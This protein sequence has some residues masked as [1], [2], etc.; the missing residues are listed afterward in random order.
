MAI[1]SADPSPRIPELG[2]V[3]FKPYRVE[4]GEQ[5][6]IYTRE[7]CTKMMEELR[8]KHIEDINAELLEGILLRHTGH[9]WSLVDITD[10]Y[11]DERYKLIK[12]VGTKPGRL[13]GDTGIL[14]FLLIDPQ[15]EY[16]TGHAFLPGVPG[17]ESEAGRYAYLTDEWTKN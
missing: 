5:I 4:Y 1:L 2:Y 7:T 9:K 13:Y 3:H 14:N 6:P 12:I 16:E 8:D 11:E 17:P 10:R 15:I